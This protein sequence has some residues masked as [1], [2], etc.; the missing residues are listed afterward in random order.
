[1]LTTNKKEHKNMNDT[2]KELDA[3]ID[4]VQVTFKALNQFD[5]MHYI[6]QFDSDLMTHENRGRFRYVG[7]W[8][9]GGIEILTPSADY[10]DMG[11]HLYMTGSACRAFEIYLK[12]QQR[13]WY[14]FFKECLQYGGKFTRLDIAIDDRKPYLSIRELNQKI[15][16]GECISKFRNRVLLESGT[17]TGEDTGCTINLGS[18][19]SLC[20][21]VFYEKNYEQSKK[22]GLPVESYGA[23]NRYEIRLKKET[24]TNCVKELVSRKNVCFIG[25]E[26]IN[27]YMRITDKSDTDTSRSR[28]KIWAPWEQLIA[29]MDKL[30]LSMHP[31]PRTLEQKKQWIADYVAPTLKMIQ[32]AD[33]NL[34]EEFLKNVIDQT[35]LKKNQKKIVEDY[36]FSKSEM[37]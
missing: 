18:G 5:I 16:N 26:I 15:K 25:L 32:I 2:K 22:T 4:W 37:E 20:S 12:A 9:F 10:L 31:A 21:M 29:G 23:W 36:L 35:T 33:D 8:T 7:K 6:L 30:K 1:M 27:Y 11:Y 19:E 34:G 13:T 24:A 17:T 28:W 3:V 14:D